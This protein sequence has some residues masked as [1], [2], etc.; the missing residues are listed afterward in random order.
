MSPGDVTVGTAKKLLRF[1]LALLRGIMAKP[2]PYSQMTLSGYRTGPRNEKG[3][4]LQFLPKNG[5]R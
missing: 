1:G 4:A 2:R 5:T 3:T